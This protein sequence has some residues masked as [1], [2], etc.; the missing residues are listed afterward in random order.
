VLDDDGRPCVTGKRQGWGVAVA[1]PASPQPTIAGQP[2]PSRV[3]QFGFVVPDL[4]QAINGWLDVGV[5]P[6]LTITAIFDNEYNG[7]RSTPGVAIALAQVGGLQLELIHPLD[8]EASAY[9]V[10]IAAGGGPG[11]VQHCGFVVDDYSKAV[12]NALAVGEKVQQKGSFFGSHFTY[13][14]GAAQI[15]SPMERVHLGD[16]GRTKED[17]IRKAAAA[18]CQVGEIIEATTVTKGMFKTVADAAT[19]WD[20]K[21]DAVRK[22]LGP[23]KEAAFDLQQMFKRIERR[24]KERK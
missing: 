23:G 10:W 3:D 17:A 14:S 16:V 20:G 4:E 22:L 13:L 21:T 15:S 8:D 24:F 18:G 6:W 12:S 9:R 19:S 2:Y 11:S 5:G 7:R 1:T